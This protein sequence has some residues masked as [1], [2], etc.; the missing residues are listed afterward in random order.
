MVLGGDGVGGCVL[1]DCLVYFKWK[2]SRVLWRLISEEKLVN[3][4]SPVL[5]NDYSVGGLFKKG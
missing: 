3:I 1:L 2:H 5:F 4:N